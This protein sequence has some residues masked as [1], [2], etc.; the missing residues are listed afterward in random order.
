MQPFQVSIQTRDTGIQVH[1]S[2]PSHRQS[3]HDT[4]HTA[5]TNDMNDSERPICSYNLTFCL[6]SREQTTASSLNSF[7]AGILSLLASVTHSG[8]P[9]IR[10]SRANKHTKLSKSKTRSVP[11]KVSPNAER[12][13]RQP[14]ATAGKPRT[15]T[16][17]NGMRRVV[18]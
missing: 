5:V 12:F 8:E 1:R 18:A 9:L 6:T 7:P 2:I 10:K 17:I 15:A 11:H 14:V 4:R 16:V 3:S 13:D